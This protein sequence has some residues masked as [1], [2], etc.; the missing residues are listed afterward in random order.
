MIFQPWTRPPKRAARKKVSFFNK[1]FFPR[2]YIPFL[3][4]KQ[5][6]FA[7]LE[8]ELDNPDLVKELEEKDVE[9]VLSKSQLKKQKRN[10]KKQNKAQIIDSEEEPEPEE[11]ESEDEIPPPKQNNKEQVLILRF[12]IFTVIFGSH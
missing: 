3:D 1:Y 10:Q 2:N 7:D 5:S 12:K 11:A 4:K 8:E 9:P 6:F